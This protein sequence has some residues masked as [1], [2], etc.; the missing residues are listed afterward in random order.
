MNFCWVTINVKDMEQSLSFYQEIIGLDIDRRLNPM[1]GTEIVF[2]GSGETKVELIRNEKNNDP[3]Y[4][5][6]ISLGFTVDSIDT[7]MELLASKGVPIQS[8][9]FQPNPMI[10]FVYVLDPDGVKIQ[11]V[12]NIPVK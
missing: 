8:G 4:G 1:P 2:L 6:D 9:P 11:F 10:R 12:E 3:R 7:C 5:T